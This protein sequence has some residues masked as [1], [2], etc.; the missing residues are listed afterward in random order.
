M[1][2]ERIREAIKLRLLAL[3][4]ALALT[5]YAVNPAPG[6]VQIIKRD[7][8]QPDEHRLEARWLSAVN[9]DAVWT[10]AHATQSVLAPLSTTDE[11]LDTLEWPE[12]ID[13]TSGEE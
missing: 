7:E 9:C 12:I 5:W 1:R 3:V 8:E 13:I 2:E 10:Q 11:D 6:P 4:L